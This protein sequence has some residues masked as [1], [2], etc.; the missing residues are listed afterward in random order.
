MKIVGVAW[1]QTAVDKEIASQ[2]TDSC[3]CSNNNTGNK[4]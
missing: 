4:S 2:V 1:N 3:D